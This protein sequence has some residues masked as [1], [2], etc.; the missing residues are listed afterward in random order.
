MWRK[1]CVLMACVW[2]A[3][4]VPAV[5][6]WPDEPTV[7]DYVRNDVENVLK[8]VRDVARNTAEF[9]AMI[10][11]ARRELKAT[12]S[13]PESHAKAEQKFANLMFA[14]DLYYADQFMYEGFTE[15]ARK[16]AQAAALLGGG[17]VDGGIPEDGQ[18]AFEEW[19]VGLRKSMGA[20]GHQRLFNTA[21]NQDR[22]VQAVKDNEPLYR[23]YKVLRDQQER[24][25]GVSQ[26]VMAERAK[27]QRARKSAEAARHAD[28]SAGLAEQKIQA[29]DVDAWRVDL[30]TPPL[31]KAL[32]AASGGGQQM[33]K[34]VYGPSLNSSGEEV[35][36]HH[37]FWYR[38]APSN[39]AALRSM[40]TK[41]ALRYL[42]NQGLEKCPPSANSALALVQAAMASSGHAPVSSDG[43]RPSSGTDPQQ[44]KCTAM[45][46]ELEQ[47]RAAAASDPAA[48][49]RLRTLQRSY[50]REGCR[51]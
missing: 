27:L 26:R 5:Q 33:L 44:K 36:G 3:G 35:F 16:A 18:Q 29:L 30:E 48:S 8:A 19:V 12:A 43:R 13:N 42:G 24:N 49:S 2:F 41:G 51:P 9:N 10:A 21:G 39:L 38:K 20:V 32:F 45:A 37:F 47:A 46:G 28:G 11:E 34:C 6:S 22:M 7:G 31:R 1:K 15:D 25:G 17:S 23:K 50:M 14:K 40:D 4:D